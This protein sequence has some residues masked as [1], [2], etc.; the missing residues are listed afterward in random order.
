MTAD[1]TGKATY[2]DDNKIEPANEVDLEDMESRRLFCLGEPRVRCN[3]KVAH[4]VLRILRQSS[5]LLP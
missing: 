4:Q 3:R 1:K 2:P 5:F